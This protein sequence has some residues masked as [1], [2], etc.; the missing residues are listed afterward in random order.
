MELDDLKD[1]FPTWFWGVG[2]ILAVGVVALLVLW[3]VEHP[4]RSP[5]EDFAAAGG[6]R[7]IPPSADVA[8]AEAAEAAQREA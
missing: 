6:A 4:D 8:A 3:Y 1:A 5:W 7:R 2:A